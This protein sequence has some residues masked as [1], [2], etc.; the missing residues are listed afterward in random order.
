ML[1]N[2]EAERAL[3]PYLADGE[4]LLWIGRPDPT[5]LF[6]SPDLYMVPFSLVWTGFMVS[7][8]FAGGFAFDPKF[9]VFALMGAFFFA[10]GAYML[11]GRFI[12]KRWRR[13]RTTYAV[14]DRSVMTLTR[15][16]RGPV[17]KSTEISGLHGVKLEL[18]RGGRGSVYFGDVPWMQAYT[19]NAGMGIFT[20]GT[21]AS[22]V[23]FFDISDARDVY[24]LVNERRRGG[25]P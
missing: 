12:Y 8:L 21:S 2:R 6:A 24:A 11:V 17:F 18:G 13:G 15:G 22:P 7:F 19:E 4:Q 1:V 5:V 10:I 3:R 9:P 20:F 14:S 16:I 25:Q 23:M